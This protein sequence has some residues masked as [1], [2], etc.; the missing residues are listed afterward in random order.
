LRSAV[1]SQDRG[2]NIRLFLAI[3]ALFAESATIYAV[4]LL[5]HL[6]H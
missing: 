2:R 5:A 1:S 6:H 4:A 3:A